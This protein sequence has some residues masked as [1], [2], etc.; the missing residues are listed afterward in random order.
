MLLLLSEF[1]AFVLGLHVGFL[2]YR[3]MKLHTSTPLPLNSQKKNKIKKSKCTLCLVFAVRS[4]A[5]RWVST[6]PSPHN[7]FVKK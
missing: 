7:Q 3:K 1:S 4:I 5:G 6:D 2:L